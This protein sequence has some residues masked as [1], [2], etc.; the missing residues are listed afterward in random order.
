MPFERPADVK[1]GQ[2]AGYAWMAVLPPDG[3]KGNYR[4]R[5]RSGRSRP[6]RSG[7]VVGEKRLQQRFDEGEVAR[8]EQGGP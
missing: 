7:W 3:R 1:L 5:G 6:C 4:G 8:W 2:G